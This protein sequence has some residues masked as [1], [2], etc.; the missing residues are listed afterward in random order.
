MEL[1][2]E[3]V[4]IRPAHLVPARA[5]QE[6]LGK[7]LCHSF[8][9]FLLLLTRRLDTPKGWPAREVSAGSHWPPRPRHVIP[10]RNASS[11]PPSIVWSIASHRISISSSH[12]TL[13]TPC[14][15]S[16]SA[17]SAVYTASWK[18]T[19]PLSGL[20]AVIADRRPSPP[21]PARPPRVI[22]H[23][24]SDS[25]AIVIFLNICR[26]FPIPT[27]ILSIQLSTRYDNFDRMKVGPHYSPQSPW[28]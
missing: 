19:S 8:H 10:G 24:F 23:R 11:P 1:W 2:P 18:L 12:F 21:S 4:L 6:D 26:E 7:T 28:R 13:S 17:P 5:T 15:S 20:F 22:I 25:E 16:I 3:P 14:L 27:L 9:S